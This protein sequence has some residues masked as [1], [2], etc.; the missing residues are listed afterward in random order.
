MLDIATRERVLTN[1]QIVVDDEVV[2]GSLRLDAGR[3]VDIDPGV[4]G[5]HGE[6]LEGDLL[7]PGLVDLHTDNLERHFQPRAGVTWDGVAA[8]I[9]HDAQ[10][11]S[12]GITTVYDS[13]TIGAAQGWDARAEMVGPMIEG[14]FS[15]VDAG[16]LRIDHLL[17]LRCE[18][19]HPELVEI[20]ERHRQHGPVHMVSL[21][22]H[23]PGD[24][25]SPDIEAYK[26]RYQRGGMS[27]HEVEAH[28]RTLIEASQE[29]GPSN[30]AAIAERAR[31]AGI[32][33]ATHDDRTAE[34]VD[35][36]IEMGA[37]FTEFPTTIEAAERAAEQGLPVLMGSPNLVRGSSHSGNVS[38]GELV[39]AG[40]LDLLASDYIPASLIKGAFRLTQAPYDLSLPMAIATVTRAPAQAAGLI[41]R[42]RIA[43]GLQADLVRV[44]L[45]KD[46][47]I[48]REVWRAGRRVA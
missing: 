12:A 9:A 22:D 21:M 45:I 34:H 42:G 36:A 15:A 28:V 31:L 30:C 7:I 14:L 18:I 44:R 10:V 26:Q 33:L 1:A 35:K 20:F 37:C 40:L 38:A 5:R 48:V 25:Q 6:D 46:R 2:S 4:A 47:P 43:V 27:D 16:M 13:L 23:A 17:H 3:I 29:F 19:T 41:D 8:A 39:Q 24:R 11:A 32:P